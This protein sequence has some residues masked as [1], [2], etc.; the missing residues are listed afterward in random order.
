MPLTY[1][2]PGSQYELDAVIASTIGLISCEEN[3]DNVYLSVATWNEQVVD[4]SEDDPAG[5]YI[6]GNVPDLGVRWIL[7]QSQS[8][9]YL[10]IAC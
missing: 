8:V 9:G 2:S 5:A 1:P 10:L 4:I 3:S 6:W 7:T